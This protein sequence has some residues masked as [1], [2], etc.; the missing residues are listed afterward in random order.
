MINKNITK[1]TR[2]IKNTNTCKNN[3]IYIYI[4]NDTY[5]N[6]KLYIYININK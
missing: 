6:N 1:I 5:N 3:Y 2:P 4:N